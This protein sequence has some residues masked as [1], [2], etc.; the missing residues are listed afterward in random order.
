MNNPDQHTLFRAIEDARRILGEDMATGSRDAKGTLERLLAV[1]DRDD[2]IHALD[3]MNRV[4][5]A[6]L[7]RF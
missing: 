1:L 2:V 7:A 3:R 6:R 5:V 4:P